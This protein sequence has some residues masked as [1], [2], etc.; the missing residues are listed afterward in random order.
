MSAFGMGGW[1]LGNKHM[2]LNTRFMGSVRRGIPTDANVIVACQKGLRSLSA[3]EQLAKNGY[4]KVA[5][6]TGGFD[7]AEPGDLPVKG[8]KDIR[9]AGNGG[10]SDVVGWTDAHRKAN[11]DQTVYDGPFGTVLKIALAIIFLDALTAVPY[12]DKIF[13]KLP[14]K[15]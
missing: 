1:W 8:G 14:F 11:K 2:R 13:D 15:I 4:A 5:W 10:L 7:S 6:V 12:L 3:C 9:F